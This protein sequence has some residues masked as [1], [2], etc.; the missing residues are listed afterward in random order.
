MDNKNY[1]I[2]MS[3]GLA[4]I[5]IGIWSEITSLW[6]VEQNWVKLLSSAGTITIGLYLLFFLLGL[7]FL[8]TGAWRVEPLNQ[9]AR[10]VSLSIAAR[11]LIVTALFLLYTY[12][13]LFSVWQPILAQP[14]T[15]FMFALGFA[16]IILFII[17]PHREQQLGLSELAITLGIF[18]LPAHHP[19]DARAVYRCTGVSSGDGRRFYHSPGSGVCADYGYDD[20]SGADK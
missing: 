17:A 16:Q 9:M 20:G 3:L 13:Y 8:L 12:I 1:G 10:R 6:T 2:L 18:S 11:W 15:Q 5:A 7:Y 19:G 4:G 14:W